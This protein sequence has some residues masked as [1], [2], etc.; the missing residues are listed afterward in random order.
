MSTSNTVLNTGSQVITNYNTAKIFVYNNRYD[1]ANFVNSTYDDI[2]LA[3][4]T[5]LGKVSADGT[6][7]PLE[8]DASDGSQYPV[9]ILSADVIVAAGD[10]I[11]LPYCVSG[12]VVEDKLVLTKEG[13]TLQTV[14]S[15]RS[16]YDRIGGDTVGVKIVANNENTILDNQ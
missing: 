10:E 3:A 9:G 1:K 15:G 13:D 2:E 16:I 4:G 12:D 5:V 14:I 7:V 8:S 6:I 11:E